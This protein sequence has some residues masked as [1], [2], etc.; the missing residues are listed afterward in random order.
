M[1]AMEFYAPRYRYTDGGV[2]LMNCGSDHLGYS[3]DY[4]KRARHALNQVLELKKNALQGKQ[5]Q[6]AA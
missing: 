5:E 3:A 6:S 1:S 2:C 4:G